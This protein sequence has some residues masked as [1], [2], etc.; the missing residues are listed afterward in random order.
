MLKACGKLKAESAGAA[1]V[2]PQH[3]NLL[4]VYFEIY[5]LKIE[6][7][8]RREMIKNTENKSITQRL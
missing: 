3:L 2:K 8:V 5:L 4:E 6:A 1:H 7:L